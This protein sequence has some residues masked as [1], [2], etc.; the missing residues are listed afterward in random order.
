MK[1]YLALFLALF[2]CHGAPSHSVGSTVIQ[3]LT[4]GG[5]VTGSG[6][7]TVVSS[8]SGTAP[9]NVT[10]GAMAWL[11]SSTRTGSMQNC[12]TGLGSTTCYYGQETT[13]GNA[14]WFFQGVSGQNF[15]NSSTELGL[16]TGNSFRT[17][18]ITSTLVGISLPVG[19]YSTT[20]FSWS[21]TASAI[22]CGT[23]GTQTITAAQAIT[24]GLTVTTGTL[25]SPCILD[26][27]TNASTGF[28]VVDTTG[29]G[30]ITTQNLEFKN[31]TQTQSL[32]ALPAGGAV[33]VWTHGTN[34]IVVN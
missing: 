28:Y 6:S 27:S 31:G 9:V 32:S 16:S 4:L 13:P 19:G 7:A 18:D 2:A 20:P 23:G 29:V 25:S 26:F 15:I 10:N 30:T 14:N 12:S 1:K 3:P 5:D 17:I 34:H 11:T 22:V 21:T 8:I 24:P 33:L